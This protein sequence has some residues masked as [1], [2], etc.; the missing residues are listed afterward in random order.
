[1]PLCAFNDAVIIVFAGVDF[2]ATIAALPT[3]VPV[4]Y[5]T[6]VGTI[7]IRSFARFFH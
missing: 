7:L 4:H 6:A 3:T 5:A 2:A 1:M